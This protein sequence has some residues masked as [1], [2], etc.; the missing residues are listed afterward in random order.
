LGDL[1]SNLRTAMTAIHTFSLATP[2]TGV[3]GLTDA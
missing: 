3:T 2:I 1:E